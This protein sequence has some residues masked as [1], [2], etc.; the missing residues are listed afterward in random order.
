MIT[1]IKPAEDRIIEY[2]IRQA[3]EPFSY[4]EVGETRQ[5]PP[6]G[7]Q[8]DHHRVRLGQG[9]D[10]WRRACE[11]IRRWQMFPRTMAEICWPDRPIDE[12]TI[13][14]VLFRAGPVWAL[15]PC[16]I[17]Y[18]LDDETPDGREFGFAYGTLPDHV[19][20]GEERFAVEW[21]H[22]DDS[23]W[24]DLSAFSRPAHW[25]TRVGYPYARWQQARFRR[26]SGEA[27]REA[28][29]NSA[30]DEAR[31]RL[32]RHATACDA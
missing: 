18:T 25:L 32:A 6:R 2:L 16:R 17:V 14:G 28:A 3:D 24:Y 5:E 1:F 9:E 12:G 27:M 21:R 20:C 4:R 29:A 15:S 31:L 26:L 23:V 13:V 10:C 11:A 30:D 7:F 19:E 8:F 22:A